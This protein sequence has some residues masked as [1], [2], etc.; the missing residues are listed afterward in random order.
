MPFT[1]SNVKNTNAG[2]KI[3]TRI[4]LVEIILLQSM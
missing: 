4:E 3:Y 2:K 1:T